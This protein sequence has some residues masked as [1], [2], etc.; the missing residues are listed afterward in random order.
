MDW[1][2]ALRTQASLSL[3]PGRGSDAPG[4]HWTALDC[5][6]ASLPSCSQSLSTDGLIHVPAR[7]VAVP[8][9]ALLLTLLNKLS[10][11][12]DLE[13]PS[14]SVR[15]TRSIRA[16]PQPLSYPPGRPRPHTYREGSLAATCRDTFYFLRVEMVSSWLAKFDRHWDGASVLSV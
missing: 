14:V 2:D 6:S 8:F 3:C 5:D 11:C 16:R 13:S 4:L 9:S 7:L 1:Q 15:R 12:T 10:S